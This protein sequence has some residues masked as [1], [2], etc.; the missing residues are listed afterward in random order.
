MSSLTLR[1]YSEAGFANNPELKSQLG[2]VVVLVDKF[3]NAALIH[4]AS[5]K[6]RRVVRS[7]LA[8]EL[9]ASV[10]S[11]DFREIMSHDLNLISGN[12]FPIHLM[13]DSKY[14]F[15]TITKIFGVSEKRLMI[16]I[17]TLRQSYASGEIDK[18][19]HIPTC[20][21][22]ADAFTKTTSPRLLESLMKTGK[23]QHDVNLWIIHKNNK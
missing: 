6:T 23:L 12:K 4:Y 18:I 10:A 17:S 14:I 16:D 21:N 2:I 1:E 11:H 20:N 3:E 13:T 9:F 22:L 7:V 19:A 8:A 5:W 15:D